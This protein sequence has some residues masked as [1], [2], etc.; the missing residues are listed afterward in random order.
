MIRIR[1]TWSDNS[2]QVGTANKLSR[3]RNGDYEVTENDGSRT[4]IPKTA[5]FSINVR[6][7]RPDEEG[8]V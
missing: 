2:V 8:T 5:V 4:Y 3:D 1:V 7:V 6:D